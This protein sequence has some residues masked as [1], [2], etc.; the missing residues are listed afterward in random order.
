[1]T[2]EESTTPDVPELGRQMADALSRWDLDAVMSFYAPGAVQEMLDGVGTFEGV[3][4]IRRFFEEWQASFEDLL[5]E[6][7]EVVDFREGVGFA[8]Y[9][10]V[11]R[12]VGGAGRVEH[13]R[14]I[15]ILWVDGKITR[16]KVYLDPNEARAVAERLAEERG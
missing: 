5:T 11:G 3:D 16:A 12:P 15:V 1:M 8:S 9:R 6:V 4:A 2:A 7:E 13:R 10:E 14:A